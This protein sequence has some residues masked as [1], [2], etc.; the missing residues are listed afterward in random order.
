[1]NDAW[2]AGRESTPEQE[3]RTVGTTATLLV[4]RS[5]NRVA[6]TISAPKTN[7]MWLS[8]NGDAAIGVGIRIP[9]GSQPLQLSLS[10]NG[11]MV[12]GPVSAIIA[13]AAE[14]I[15]YVG[16]INSCACPASGR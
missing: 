13:T 15:T 10:D 6:L 4:P 2:H 7:E 5:P 3:T 1:M 11:A 16:A 8:W 9:A 12:M 14:A